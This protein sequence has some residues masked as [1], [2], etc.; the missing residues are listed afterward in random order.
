MVYLHENQI[1]FFTYLS[2]TQVIL[3][4]EI[5]PEYAARIINKIKTLIKAYEFN[6]LLNQKPDSLI[7]TAATNL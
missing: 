6:Q 7:K 2:V 3:S 4:S 5:L 1:S